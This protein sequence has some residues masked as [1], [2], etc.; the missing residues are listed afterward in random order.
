M[1]KKSE[2]LTCK[3][4]S[5]LILQRWFC[6]RLNILNYMWF[7]RDTFDISKSVG[8]HTFVVFEIH[9]NR[10][11]LIW[12]QLRMHLMN[13]GVSDASRL[14]NT[15]HGG[16]TFAESRCGY[17]IIHQT[18]TLRIIGSDR[19][20]WRGLWKRLWARVEMGPRL[21]HAA[22]TRQH[23]WGLSCRLTENCTDSWWRGI[24]RWIKTRHS[25]SAKKVCTGFGRQHHHDFRTERVRQMAVSGAAFNT[26]YT[27]PQKVYTSTLRSGRITHHLVFP[28]EPGSLTACHSQRAEQWIVAAACVS[29]E[30]VD[31]HIRL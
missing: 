18:W 6:Y 23:A 30:G 1:C 14:L 19:Q 27:D 20:G 17:L 24:S 13:P 25:K 28:E 2:V 21:G 22:G 4:M 31:V 10:I 7:N 11:F 12:F 5:V 8:L 9:V 3:R 15:F 26:E 16:I 29:W